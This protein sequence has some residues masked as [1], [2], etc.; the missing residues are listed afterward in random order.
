MERK[1]NGNSKGKKKMQKQPPARPIITRC[2]CR[3]PTQTD[4]QKT[5][6]E[7]KETKRH[8]K[9]K[10]DI[11]SDHDLSSDYDNSIHQTEEN[12]ADA[13]EI[14][15]ENLNNN[16]HNPTGP[17]SFRSPTTM[18]NKRIGLLHIFL[19]NNKRFPC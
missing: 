2:W 12:K 4:K 9:C 7:D 18:Y 15:S 6:K 5:P 13:E 14:L 8:Q 17:D 10:E 16:N 19:Q 3:K 11:V 1:Q